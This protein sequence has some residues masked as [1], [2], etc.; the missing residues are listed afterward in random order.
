[1]PLPCNVIPIEVQSV[2][3]QRSRDPK[4]EIIG[5][6]NKAYNKQIIQLIFKMLT[7]NNLSYKNL[8]D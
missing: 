8:S 1:M 3:I 4:I 2:A 6:L 7:R 5:L